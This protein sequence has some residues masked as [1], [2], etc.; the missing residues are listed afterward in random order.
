MYDPI[1][2]IAKMRAR[3]FDPPSIQESRL[4]GRWKYSIR[5]PMSLSVAFADGWL[6][7]SSF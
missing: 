5:T 2:V 6:V 7:A 1:I 4:A 3:E